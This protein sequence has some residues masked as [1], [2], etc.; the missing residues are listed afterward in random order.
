MDFWVLGTFCFLLAIL[1][2]FFIAT[3][4]KIAVALSELLIGIAAAFAI[5]YFFPTFSN[6]GAAKEKEVPPELPAP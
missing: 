6:L 5:G 1:A 2:R 4:L 3:R